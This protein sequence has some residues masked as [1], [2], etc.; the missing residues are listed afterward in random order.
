[1]RF[2]TIL[3]VIVNATKETANLTLLHACT[4]ATNFISKSTMNPANQQHTDCANMMHQRHHDFAGK[5][6][7]DFC[8]LTYIRLTTSSTTKETV[9]VMLLRVTLL[10]L[11][12][13]QG[14]R[15]RINHAR[16]S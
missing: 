3:R 11:S 8:T 1:M 4:R 2:T 16:I 9:N 13:D 6:Y 14:K 15:A 5:T 7:F 10:F 12:S